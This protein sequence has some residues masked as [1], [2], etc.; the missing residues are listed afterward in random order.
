MKTAF[1]DTSFYKALLNPK[2]NWRDSVISLSAAYRGNVV[3]SKYLLCEL[4]A[5]MSHR[6]LHQLFVE[7][8]KGMESAPRVGTLPFRITS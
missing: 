6:H 8:V 5:L 3:T 2:D 7:L 4:G 1:A